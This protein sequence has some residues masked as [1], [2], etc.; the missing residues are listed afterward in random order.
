MIRVLIVEDE[1][2]IR[3]GLI[4]TY[5]WSA[6]NCVIV[7]SASDGQ[8]GLKYINELKPDLVITDIKMPV[9]NGLEMI[10]HM[11]HSETE[12]VVLTGFGEFS[13]AQQA[14]RLGVA[15]YLLKPVDESEM[16][17]CIEEIFSRRDDLQNDAKQRFVDALIDQLNLP[18]PK[19]SLD[20]SEN[21]ALM[22]DYIHENYAKKIML[23]DVSEHLSLSA[24]H[25]NSQFKAETGTTFNDYLNRYRIR[26]A[27]RLL[28]EGDKKVYR[29]AEMVGIPDYKYFVRVFKKYAGC[30]PSMIA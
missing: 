3:R 22:L 10:S 2:I 30:A 4:C 20:R 6:H 12:V 24:N 25:L 29:V 21:V 14:L 27:I 15:D 17:A 26:V 23:K 18:E 5:D 7:G 11:E 9:M 1:D 16:F 28:A 19:T 8:E 13:L